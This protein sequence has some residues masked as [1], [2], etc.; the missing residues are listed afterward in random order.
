MQIDTSIVRQILKPVNGYYLFP[1]LHQCPKFIF[2][3]DFV[4][5]IKPVGGSGANFRGLQPDGKFVNFS[6][7]CPDLSPI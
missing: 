7:D 2:G 5:W 3:W 4:G 1:N 6:C